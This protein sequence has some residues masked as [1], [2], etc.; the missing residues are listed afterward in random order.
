MNSNARYATF[1]PVASIDDFWKNRLAMSIEKNKKMNV[2]CSIIVV[3]DT[4]T[5]KTDL[6]GKLADAILTK[7]GHTVKNKVFC[8]NDISAVESEICAQKAD[9]ILTIGGTGISKKDL[10]FSVVASLIKKELPGF[11]ELFRALSF[12]EIGTK[13]MLS[14][15]TMGID[16]KGRII[17]ALPGSPLAVELAL[18]KI[19][20]KELSH[21]VSELRK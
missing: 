19:I 7:S 8:P 4:K 21:L 15:A 10:T 13:A 2:T 14:R 5:E 1:P 17:C 12:K 3:T 20:V 18:N 9:F 16:S 11:G 6:S